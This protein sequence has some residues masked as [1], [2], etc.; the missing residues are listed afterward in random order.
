MAKRGRSRAHC[1]YVKRAIVYH[2]MIEIAMTG[3]LFEAF[4]GTFF[5]GVV[6]WEGY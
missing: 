5:E 6:D 2:G 4:R 3:S 1:P